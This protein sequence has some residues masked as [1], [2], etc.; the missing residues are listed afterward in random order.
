MIVSDLLDFVASAFVNLVILYAS[1]IPTLYTSERSWTITVTY[2][3]IRLYLINGSQQ[4]SRLLVVTACFDRFG[5]CSE[6]VRLRQFFRVHV[7][8]RYMIPFT[9]I[10]WL[11]FPMHM[12]IFGTAANNTCTF[13][14][15]SELY[16]SIYVIIVIGFIP[17]ASMLLVSLLT[18]SIVKYEHSFIDK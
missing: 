5:L 2:I 16:N 10:T 11:I 4:M 15:V 12:L 13:P 8:R 17:S 3:K 9:I 18:S 1:I 14:G 7:A 6:S